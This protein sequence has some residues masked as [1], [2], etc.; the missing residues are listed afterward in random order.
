MEVE[1]NRSISFLDV[2]ITRTEGGKLDH[3]VYRKSTHTDRYLHKNSNHHPQQKRGMIKTLIDRANRICQENN[4]KDEISHIQNALMSNGY[5]KK[6]INRTLHPNKQSNKTLNDKEPVGKAYLPYIK[7]VTDRIGKLLGKKN[8]KTVYL[9]TRK[10]AQHLR[11]PKDN[12]DPLSSAG[13]YRI[14]CACGSVY[15]GTTKRSI[16]T[17]ISEHKRCCRL[18]QNEKSAVA[19]HTLSDGDHKILFSETSL[20]SNNNHYYSRMSREAIEI[21]KNTNNFNKKEELTTLNRIWKPILS[22]H[23]VTNQ[24]S[25]CTDTQTQRHRDGMR[26]RDNNSHMAERD[27]NSLFN[28]NRGRLTQNNTLDVESTDSSHITSIEGEQ[29]IRH[30]Y[31]LRSRTHHTSHMD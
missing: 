20:L 2:H 12:R 26:D 22:S 27:N 4:I 17:R 18:G 6:E 23:I 16:N 8:I 30:T 28:I 15:V 10:I 7:H 11:S 9:P 3:R 19:E 21:F 24:V 13:V 5:T 1:K 31:T 29:I 14:P 25:T